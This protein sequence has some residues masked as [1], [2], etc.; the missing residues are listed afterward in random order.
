MQNT[1]LISFPT[2]LLVCVVLGFC[3]HETSG[4]ACDRFWLR[5]DALTTVRFFNPAVVFDDGLGPALYAKAF[6]PEMPVDERYRFAR[7]TGRSWE[8]QYVPLQGITYVGPLDFGTGPRL[9]AWAALQG[10]QFS[11]LVFWN[12]ATWEDDVQPRLWSPGP[13][14]WCYPTIGFQGGTGPV[15]YGLVHDTAS[16]SAVAIAKWDGVRWNSI[17]YP[18]SPFNFDFGVFDIGEGPALYFFGQFD[19]I[20]GVPNT[21]GI[22]RWDGQQ[23]HALGPGIHGS[24]FSLCVFDSGV[25]KELY[26]AGGL[27][28]IGTTPARFA[29][30][31]GHQWTILPFPLE[32]GIAQITPFD[33][34]LGP[35][36]VAV[37]SMT[38]LNGQPA[39]GFAKF[40]GT[41][42]HILPGRATPSFE[43]RMLAFNED[44]RGPSLF[45]DAGGGIYDTAQFVGC[46]GGGT[47]YADCDNADA[48]QRLTANDFMCFLTRF[49]AGS[50]P[51]NR[52]DP[53]ADCNQDSAWNALDFQCFLTKFA[54]GCP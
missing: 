48:L 53:Y 4:Q 19:G 15:V 3:Q 51:N 7:W 22:A 52:R 44:P 24:Y 31:D 6:L 37:G 25:G 40:D 26:I 11:K 35:G 9:Y 2:R 13:E 21:R 17:G 32:F 49:L 42:W 5:P 18:L 16:P 46:A 43:I 12:G 10:A 45:I 54:A 36:V 38:S 33:D 27:S 30:W 8:L 1:P 47:C 50:F 20:A 29:K 34:G 28:S 23:W 41:N 39:R 14:G